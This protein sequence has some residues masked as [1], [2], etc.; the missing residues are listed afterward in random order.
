MENVGHT[1]DGGRGEGDG[2]GEE[3]G[4]VGGGE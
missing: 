1:G 4:E 2:E 3:G